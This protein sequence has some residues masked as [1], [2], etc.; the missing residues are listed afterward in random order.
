MCSQSCDRAWLVVVP[1]PSLG[2]CTAASRYRLQPERCTTLAGGAGNGKGYT[3]GAKGADTCHAGGLEQQLSSDTE[4][5]WSAHF[6]LAP[7]K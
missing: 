4:M 6:T 3:G 7:G 2:V 5:E 1:C